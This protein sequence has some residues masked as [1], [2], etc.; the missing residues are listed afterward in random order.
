MNSKLVKTTGVIVMLAMT[1]TSCVSK[2]GTSQQEE[3]TTG[4]T[5]SIEGV[6]TLQLDN[7][8]AVWL[9]DNGSDKLMPRTL[10]AD[11]PDTLIEQLS[12]QEG[13][14]STVSAFWV[15]ANGEHILFDAGVG[16]TDGKLMERLHA[17]GVT[18]DDVRYLYL[19]H[20]HFDHIGGMMC[21]DSIRFPQAEVYVAK[22][23]YDAWMQMPAEQNAKVVATMEAYKERLHLFAFGDILPGGVLAID[24]AGH[25]PGHT[26]FKAGSLLVVG[27]I[28]HGAALQVPHPEYCAEY[29]MDKAKAVEAR[30]RLMEYA[31][32]NRLTMAGMH[33]PAPA[34]LDIE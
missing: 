34:F 10:F 8:T 22:A 23:E 11:A 19:T 6:D 32:D 29:D 18:P 14:P 21:G 16:G 26:A 25:T 9:Q 33:L 17:I 28:M 3:K 2:S 1:F 15:E 20:L 5:T 30:R 27:D 13:I 31:R 4:D 12:L 24:A 7:V